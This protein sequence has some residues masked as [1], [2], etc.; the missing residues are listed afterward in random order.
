[1]ASS[2]LVAIGNGTPK[3]DTFISLPLMGNLVCN[4]VINGGDGIDTVDYCLNFGVVVDLSKGT[5]KVDSGLGW[6]S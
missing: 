2:P 1:M 3:N 5:A 6:F 4:P